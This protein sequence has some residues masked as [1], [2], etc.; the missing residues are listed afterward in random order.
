MRAI[1]LFLPLLALAA[2]APLAAETGLPDE[3]AV[4]RA[5]D[6][7]PSVMAAQARLE[8]AEARATGLRK[9]PHEFTF[10][11]TYIR[12][13]VDRE[14]DFDEYDAQLSRAIRLPGKARLDR[15]IGAYG[16]EEAANLAEDARH[17]AALLLAMH[18][19]D[20]LS[21]S[22]QANVD[23][24]AVA[25]FEQALAAVTRRMELR[26]AAQLEVD[27]ASA[28]LASARLAAEQSS[29]LATL[30]RA[31]LA[32]H[33]P[34]LPLPDTAPE[35]PFPEIAEA[36]LAQ[37]RDHVISNSHEVAAAEAE[38]LRMGAVAARAK[39][40]RMADPTLGVRLFSE[41]DGHEQ[42]AGL[43]FSIPL[44][45]GHRK[46]LAQEA[47]AGAYAARA[48]EQLA[49]FTVQETADADVAEARYRLA[50]WERA[51]E[52]VAAQMA[53]LVKLRRGHELGEIDL[54]DLLLGE[55][56]VHDAFRME[57]QARAE[58][59]RAVTKLRIDSHE[60]WLAD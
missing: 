47:G 35:L 38:A 12:R 57:A 52:A 34:A 28:A 14:G 50:A 6:E 17:Q 36:E 4:A 23:R 55:R 21:A 31:P 20:W 39:K 40:D 56:M 8:A 2:A 25:N 3:A 37:L 41:R 9:G 53:A 44:G 54:A 19:Y 18:W 24:A 26:D 27:Q 51:Q 22:A 42:G 7:H 16:V 32:T 60:L 48:E 45:G 10:T 43:V 49:R 33:F 59:A 11:G 1:S 5:L 15:E 29:G 13:T 30:A 46:A 58:A